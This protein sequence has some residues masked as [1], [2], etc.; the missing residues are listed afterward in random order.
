[1]RQDRTSRPLELFVPVRR[2]SG[3]TLRAQLEGQLREAVRSGRLRPGSALP[4]TRA[5]ATQL[6]ISRGVVVEAY[7]QLA[8]EGYL[9]ARPGSATR[10]ADAALVGAPPPTPEAPPR[11][12]R[13]D[14]RP[15]VPA[16][17]SFPRSAWL[18]SLRTA[19]KEAPH[20][21]LGYGDPRGQPALRQALA[22]YLG[23]VRGVA[24]NP[25]QVLVCS[26]FAQG[27]ALVCRAL[28][29]RGARRVAME[30]PS[31]PGQRAIVT[32]SG[33]EPVPVPVDDHGIQV[34]HLAA[35]GAEVVLVTPAHQFPTGTVLAAERRGALVAWAQRN[36]A[37]IV[38]DDYDAEY[39]YD[40]EPIGAVQGLAPDRVVYAGSASKTLA[41]AL[42]LGWLVLPGWLTDAVAEQKALDDLA[43]PALEQLAFADLLGCGEVDRHLRR[44]RTRYRAR[45]DAL[46]TALAAH[47][48]QVKVRGIAA[49]LHVVAELPSQTAEVAVVAA[50]RRHSV[51]VYPMG[52]YRFGAR[53]GPPA[54][55]LG[56]GSLGEPAIRRGVALLALAISGA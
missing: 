4:S 32:A 14:F 16:L 48:P 37:V 9:V 31:H 28:G 26:G 53:A 8:A 23:R 42:R 1:M 11:P 17:D 10:V 2:A 24:A 55:V 33:L 27:T 20:A 5:L 13:Y 44:N 19:L 15:G 43:S 30:D 51:G 47:A 38:E 35:V 45:R 21:A 40:R 18:T 56:Y 25:D 39:R 46:V 50:A 49:G 22:T 34:N 52:D 7:D 3:A 12:L 41:P 54:L 36:Q 6:Q 29:R